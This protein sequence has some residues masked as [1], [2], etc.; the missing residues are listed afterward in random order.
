MSRGPGKIQKSII[1]ALQE[2]DDPILRNK[3]QWKLAF[4]N[5]SVVKTEE[6]C[7]GILEGYI[8]DP[9]IKSFQR[10]LKRLSESEQIVIKKRKLRDID[11]FIKYYPYKTAALEIFMLRTNLFPLIKTYLEGPWSR[12]T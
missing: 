1:Q 11:E 2:Q 8:E 6:L 7:E 12:F 10:A 4:Q 5:D 3:L 9:Y